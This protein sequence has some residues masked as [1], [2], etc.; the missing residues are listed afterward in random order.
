MITSPKKSKF[1]LLIIA[2]LLL[3]NIVSLFIFFN[4]RK[5]SQEVKP[6]VDRK[7]VISKYL[8]EELKFDAAQMQ[9]FDSISAKHKIATEPLFESLREE[10]EKRFQFL[11]A[12][13]YSDSA[14]LQVVNRSAE[15][16]KSL[17][18]KMLEHIKNIRSICT[19]TQKNTFDTGFYKM[20][21][22][23]RSEKKPV[24]QT[25]K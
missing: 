3:A 25:N 5:C 8:K 20:M 7:A 19:E 14:L 21:R 23:S 1:L 6:P 4:S 11:A 2:V 24:R 13:N 16:Q 10:K 15:R 17:D 9:S 12:N 22:K 18:L